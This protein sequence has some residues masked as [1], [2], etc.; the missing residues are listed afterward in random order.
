M[1]LANAIPD[2]TQFSLLWSE[3]IRKGETKAGVVVLFQRTGERVSEY[4][5][6][7]GRVFG[8]LLAI[9]PSPQK[10]LKIICMCVHSGR[11]CLTE[12]QTQMKQ[13]LQS[14]K[15]T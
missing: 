6:Q 7:S 5:G 9:S 3:S 12:I 11:R 13:N 8:F 1:V 15:L 14:S 10:M 2:F 4:F